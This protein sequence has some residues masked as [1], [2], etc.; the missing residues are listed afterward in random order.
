M[1]EF[2]GWYFIVV[3]FI[4]LLFKPFPFAGMT[5]EKIIECYFEMSIGCLFV[6]IGRLGTFIKHQ[7]K[8]DNKL[9]EHNNESE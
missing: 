7:S 8:S 3:N 5:H 6:I 4:S 1:I 9:Q 2:I